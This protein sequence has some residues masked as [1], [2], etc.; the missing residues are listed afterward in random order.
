MNDLWRPRVLR[1]YAFLAD[2]ERGGLVGPDGAIVWMCAPRWDSPAVFAALLGGQGGYAVTP[3]DPWHVWGG[4][5]EPASLIWRSR[6]VGRE[7]VECREALAMPG[8]PDRVVILRRI[9]AKDGPARVTVV[10]DVRAGFGRGPMRDLARSQGVWTGRSGTSQRS[11][12]V[13]FRWSGA[14]RARPDRDGRLRMTLTVP[15]G[16]SHDLV[17]EISALPFSDTP[18]SAGDAWAA[19]EQ[20][21]SAAV[22]AC[23]GLVAARDASHAYAVLRGLTSSS[24]GM[25]AAA[26]TSLPERLEGVRNYDYRYAWIRDQCYAG[27]AMAAHGSADQ[28]AGAVR[29]ITERVLAD[30]PGLKPA[31]T[32]GG[33]P[34]PDERGLP[35]RGYP[36]SSV[37]IGNRVRRQFQLDSLGEVLQLLA[38]AAGQGMLDADGMRAAEVAARAIERRWCEPEAGI[39]E[40]H[41]DHWTHSRLCCVAGLK[42]MA[43]ETA[44]D[45]M[46]PAGNTS[47]LAAGWS[48]LADAIMADMGKAVR[49]DGRWKRAVGDDRVDA[50]LLPSVLRGAVP[51]GDPRSVATVAAVAAELADDGFVYR[52]RHD[53]LPLHEAEGAFLLCGFWMALT[54][55]V[56]GDDVE[57]AHWFE[58]NRAACGPAGLY[59]EE[60]DVHQRQ[61]RGNVPQAFVHAG[62]LECA[63]R[64]SGDA[65]VGGPSGRLLASGRLP[66]SG[67]RTG[68]LPD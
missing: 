47:R 68:R 13:W 8:D 14:A 64:L 67:P 49:E 59:T 26:T 66:A 53:N 39:W 60:Y 21:W 52:F 31:Y 57:A 18:V 63:V 28:L 30:G 4:Y 38:A 55:H 17:L 6:W 7:I 24:G 2:G 58:R 5:Y 34:I 41:D 9:E 32:V 27:I 44:A 23:D 12:A 61:L 29:F 56:R 19:T 25:V 40:L 3:A 33:E 42:A 45:G 37:R 51:P 1:E 20:V 36:G 35:L 54:A 16:Q 65:S 22:P 48:A 11:G 46:R 62:M 43:A 50:A 10:L 15:P